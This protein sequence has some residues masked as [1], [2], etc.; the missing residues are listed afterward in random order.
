[1]RPA[2]RLVTEPQ[3]RGPPAI[4]GEGG[5]CDPLKGWARQDTSLPDTFSIEQ[6]GVDVTGFVLQFVQVFQAPEAL[7]VSRV[8]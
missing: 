4:L 7:Q 8:S 5:L 1:M 3:G 6:A 2:Q